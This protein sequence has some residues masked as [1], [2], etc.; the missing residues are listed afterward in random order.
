MVAIPYELSLKALFKSY[1]TIPG[2]YFGPDSVYRELSAKT[3]LGRTTLTSTYYLPM[4]NLS[5]KLIKK[6]H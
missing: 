2:L 5:S 6:A 3:P 4:D 1:N